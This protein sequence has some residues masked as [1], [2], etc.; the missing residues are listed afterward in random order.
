V[1]PRSIAFGQDRF[2]SELR[3]DLKARRFVPLPARERLIPKSGGKLRGL[4]ITTAPGQKLQAALIWCSMTVTRYRYW[5]ATHWARA[6]ART[7]VQSCDTGGDP[8]AWSRMS[9]CMSRAWLC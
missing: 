5:I 7:A 8:D 2:L 3:D 6:A 1:K 9:G 4:G